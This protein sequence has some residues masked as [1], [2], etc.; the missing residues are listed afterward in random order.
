MTNA[1]KGRHDGHSGHNE[2][3]APNEATATKGEAAALA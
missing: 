1:R 2:A 3:Q